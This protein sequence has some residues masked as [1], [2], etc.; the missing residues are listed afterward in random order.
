MTQAWWIIE[1]ID[2]RTSAKP[3]PRVR[4]DVRPLL[5]SARARPTFFRA[6]NIEFRR[7]IRKQS[8]VGWL[9]D[10]VKSL[11][12][13]LV[14]H[15]QPWFTEK[16]WTFYIHRTW[17]WQF[18]CRSPTKYRG[19]KGLIPAWVTNGNAMTIELSVVEAQ[20]CGKMTRTTVSLL[21]SRSG[22]AH[23]LV[24]EGENKT[25]YFRVFTLQCARRRICETHRVL[26]LLDNATEVV[27]SSWCRSR[28]WTKFELNTANQR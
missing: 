9:N 7:E 28:C 3:V 19:E 24:R 1:R 8:A 2:A 23:F 17:E 4:W 10:D 25:K 26:I 12:R 5:T 20:R 11:D 14:S 13:S 21:K 22:F 16:L 18:F 27:L 6:R 15:G